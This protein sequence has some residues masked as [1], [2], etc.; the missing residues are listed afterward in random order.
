[1]GNQDIQKFYGMSDDQTGILVRKVDPGS[2]AQG[3]LIEDDVIL[4]IDGVQV[5]SDGTVPFRYGERTE[6]NYIVQQCQI[7][8]S[9]KVQILRDKRIYNKIIPL[10][11]EAGRK[12]NVPDLEPTYYIFAGFI[13]MPLTE[14]LLYSFGGWYDA[15][16]NLSYSY[17]Y[18]TRREKNEQIVIIMDVLSDEVNVGYEYF[19]YEIVSR[20]NGKKIARIEDVIDAVKDNREAYH[21]IETDMGDKIILDRKKARSAK[22]RILKTYDIKYD[23]SKDLRSSR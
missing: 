16:L 3:Q 21:V 7:G 18:G 5:A 11:M 14:D 13:F 17:Y 4:S 2:P 1:M 20:V 15:P 10:T 22:N 19:Y 8:E 6:F 12:E 23:R 9:I